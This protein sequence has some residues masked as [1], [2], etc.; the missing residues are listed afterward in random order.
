MKPRHTTHTTIL[1]PQPWTVQ[2]GEGRSGVGSAK[3]RQ[4][5]SHNNKKKYS[6]AREKRNDRPGQSGGRSL[7]N[8]V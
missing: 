8:P 6:V 2:W 4:N 1:H 3:L 7:G 5:A